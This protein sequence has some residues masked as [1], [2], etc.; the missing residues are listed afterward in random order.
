MPDPRF[1][2]WDNVY[3]WGHWALR[4]HHII[5][6][7]DSFIKEAEKLGFKAVYKNRNDLFEQI[8][9]RDYQIILQK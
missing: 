4:E 1:I 7:M 2:D 3:R 5:W 8:C 9:T 6:D